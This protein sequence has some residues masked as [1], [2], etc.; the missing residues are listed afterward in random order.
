MAAPENIVAEL[1]PTGT[2]RAAVNTSN[3][4][5]VRIDERTGTPAG[6]SVDLANAVAAE[7]GCPI[8]VL[9]YRSAAAIL[10]SADLSEW[11][12]ALIAADPSRMDRFA[13]SPPYAFVTATYL[14]PARS[15]VR[16]A[17][18]VDVSGRRIAT[19]RDAAYTKEIERQLKNATIVYAESPSAAVDMLK[20][21]DC[22]AAAGLRQ[23]LEPAAL[24]DPAFRTLADAF[25][26]IPQT[27]AVLN[28]RKTAAVFL[29]NFVEDYLKKRSLP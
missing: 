27:V 10:A 15:D 4:A 28:T 20:A 21:G 23:S 25:S 5:L 19:A 8:S 22:D 1:A 6:P 9:K 17:A 18:D 26:E 29:A 16:Y 2:I 13:F 7:I 24:H 3:T 14:V 11:D 12:I